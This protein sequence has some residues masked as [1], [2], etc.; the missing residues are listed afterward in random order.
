ML[1]IR[2]QSVNIEHKKTF[3]KH[4]TFSFLKT[5]NHG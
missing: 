3:S 2:K 5:Q 4:K 1:N